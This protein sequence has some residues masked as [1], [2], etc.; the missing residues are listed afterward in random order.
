MSTHVFVV[1]KLKK[2]YSRRQLIFS[3]RSVKLLNADTFSPLVERELNSTL[4]LTLHNSAK[5][6]EV[7]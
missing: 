6:M 7:V 1:R 5:W 3:P 2:V 4:T